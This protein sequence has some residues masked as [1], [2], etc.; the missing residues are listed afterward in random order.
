MR[1]P[2]TRRNRNLARIRCCVNTFK[3]FGVYSKTGKPEI[4]FYKSIRGIG[5][6]MFSFQN[7]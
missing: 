4:R 1:E 2:I 5:R 3:L 7:S 6:H